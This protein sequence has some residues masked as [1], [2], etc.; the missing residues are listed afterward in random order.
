LLEHLRHRDRTAEKRERLLVVQAHR[1]HPRERLR[2]VAEIHHR[3]LDSELFDAAT[4]VGRIL[5][6]P[7]L[8]DETMDL[9]LQPHR[10]KG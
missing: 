2:A 4:G 1:H 7:G 8:A 9:V 5:G 3:G 10:M 6:A